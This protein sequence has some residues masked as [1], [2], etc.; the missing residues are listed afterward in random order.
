MA[1][2]RRQDFVEYAEANLPRLHRAAYVLCGDVHRADDVVQATL[3][4]LYVHWERARG[5]DN[6]DGY[7]YRIMVRRHLDET[8]RSW[9]RVL[10]AAD[11]PD[12]PVSDDSGGADRELIV[13][14][15]RRLPKG[16]RAAVVLRYCA[17]LSVEGTAAA[18]QCSTGNVKSQTARGLAALRVLLGE[19]AER[20]L[21]DV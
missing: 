20:G 4:S 19:M 5:A 3:T 6:L 14:A 1:D 13:A 7:V 8:R 17:D 9:W 15:L 11:P 21:S 2:R 18:L 12:R 16:Q 10:L